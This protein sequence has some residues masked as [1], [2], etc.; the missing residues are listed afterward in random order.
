MKA[1]CFQKTDVLCSG[2]AGINNDRAVFSQIRP[3]SHQRFDDLGQA[4]ALDLIARIKP[5]VLAKPCSSTTS[6]RVNSLQS[7]RFSLLCPCL[8]LAF[9]AACPSK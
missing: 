9:P 4:V 5:A 7:E 6:A 2:N 3:Q 1:V 8:A